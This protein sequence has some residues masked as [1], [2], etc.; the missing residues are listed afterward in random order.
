M[1]RPPAIASWVEF[2]GEAGIYAATQAARRRGR[3]VIMDD[4]KNVGPR[5]G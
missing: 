3:R 4:K 1:L 2:V 5:G